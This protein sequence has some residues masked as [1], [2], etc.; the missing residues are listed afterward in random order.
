LAAES[1]STLGAYR[2]W[3]V[4][5]LTSLQNFG[6]VDSN[7]PLFKNPNPFHPNCPEGDVLRVCDAGEKPDY[8]DPCHC[9]IPKN[10]D[11]PDCAEAEHLEDHVCVANCPEGYVSFKGE[12]QPTSQPGTATIKI[13][14]KK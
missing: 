6:A 12:C 14:G 1:G 2:A 9:V 5:E 11:D 13:P 8:S 4:I 7:D 3:N 10:Q